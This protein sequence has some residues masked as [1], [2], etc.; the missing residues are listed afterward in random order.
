MKTVGTNS[1]QPEEVFICGIRKRNQD[2][3]RVLSELPGKRRRV[4]KG[5]VAQ[6]KILVE[7]GHQLR[8]MQ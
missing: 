8:Q 3:S 2:D 6:S 5:D 7:A 4:S 1:S